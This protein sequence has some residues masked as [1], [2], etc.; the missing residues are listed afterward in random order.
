MN[1]FKYELSHQEITTHKDS[2]TG[3]MSMEPEVHHPGYNEHLDINNYSEHAKNI[4]I[5]FIYQ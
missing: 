4:N 1:T 3:K 5:K 2:A